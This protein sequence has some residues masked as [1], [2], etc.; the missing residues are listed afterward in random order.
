MKK[1][2]KTLVFSSSLILFFV[3]ESYAQ[4]RFS[5]NV[6]TGVYVSGTVDDNGHDV[7]GPMI[8]A[9]FVWQLNNWFSEI[10]C[11]GSIADC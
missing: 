2:I 7:V 6:G 1:L 4:N 8:G 3:N 11:K 5:L 9:E 10:G